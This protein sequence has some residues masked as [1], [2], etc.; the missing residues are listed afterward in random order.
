MTNLRRDSKCYM[1]DSWIYSP[2][3]QTYFYKIKS[4]HEN[5]S[6]YLEQHRYF[7]IYN[8]A[9]VTWQN[10]AYNMWQIDKGLCIR[11]MCVSFKAMDLRIDDT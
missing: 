2:T 7:G 4:F 1:I 8:D 5:Y 10:P 11:Y 3:S 6:A 9:R